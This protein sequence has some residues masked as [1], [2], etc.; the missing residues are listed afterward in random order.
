MLL[1]KRL[2]ILFT[3]HGLLFTVVQAQQPDAARLRLAQSYEQ[4]GEWA[5]ALPIYELLYQSDARNYVYFDGLRRAYTQL[6]QYDKAMALVRARMEIQQNDVALQAMLGTLYYQAGSERTADS[7]WNAL[8]RTDAKDTRMYRVVASQM[9][10]NRL[11][12]RAIQLYLRARAETGNTVEFAEELS[13]LYGSFQQYVQATKEL[14]NLARGNPARVASVQ[15]RLT[16]FTAR[17]EGAKQAI[18]VL[19]EEVTA[20]PK[21]ISLRVLLA[22]LY[23]ERKEFNAALLEYRVI[24]EQK[25]AKGQE[26]YNFAQ[27]ALQ[28]QA[29][30]AAAAA[31]REV[32]DEYPTRE[33]L[34]YARYGYARSIEELS[35]TDTSL[36]SAVA[37]DAQK[38]PATVSETQPSF[39]AALTLY[40]SIIS[41]Y[42]GSE[43]AAQAYFRV[44]VIRRNRFFD[45]DGA[46]EALNRVRATTQTPA[47]VFESTMNIGEAHTAKNNLAA[48]R[49]EYLRMARV[50]TPEIRD[51]ALFRMAELD[52]FDARFDSALAKIQ[53]LAS[54][55]AA[56]LANDALQL[57]YFI[58]ENKTSAPAALTAFTKADLMM[59]QN[60]LSESLQQ[61][62][63]IIRLYPTALLLD[64][65]MM[66][67]GELYVHLKQPDSA[68]AAYKK[69]AQDM[70]TSIYR[71]Y[72]Q[73][74][75]GEVY[76]QTMRNKEKAIEAYEIVLSKYPNSLHAEEARK[77]I[78]VLRGDNL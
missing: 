61:F 18:A 64:D 12:D 22:W 42:R 30:R 62:K 50:A 25:N 4:E 44:G 46:V 23:M 69:V 75:V 20:S 32:I 37:G 19:K 73:L 15:A 54:N 59:R 71:D 7:L 29:Y 3:I 70:P 16:A 27:R 10:E 24:D 58:Q 68:L 38:T 60:K 76:E 26:L 39:Q 57:Q 33:R 66:R 77:R 52:Y 14:A 53:S 34:P 56:D 74:R 72:A 40:E 31:F 1:L 5:R 47:L 65:A 78:R 41:D 43:F 55:I 21:D 8:I 2:F 51:R 48:A 49:E 13:W 63:E 11:Y 67:S 17:E 35:A 45:L 6:K 9:I 28:E 36:A